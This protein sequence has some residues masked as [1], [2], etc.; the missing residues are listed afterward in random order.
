MKAIILRTGLDRNGNMYGFIC[1]WEE[2]WDSKQYEYCLLN[3]MPV[4]N[5]SLNETTDEWE[6]EYET[7]EERKVAIAKAEKRLKE[8]EEEWESEAC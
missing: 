1:A 6:C 2:G 3:G 5:V 8:L 4:G 7:K